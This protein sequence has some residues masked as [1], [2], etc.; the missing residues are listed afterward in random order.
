MKK[1]EIKAKRPWK[2][3]RPSGYISHGRFSSIEEPLMP[4]DNMEF[5]IV[6]QADFIREYYPTGHA[7]NDPAFYPDIYREEEE[8]VYDENGDDT[9][10]KI[11]RIYKELV[12]RYAFAFQ[13]IITIKQ[14]VHLCG[15]DIQ[16]ELGAARPTDEEQEKFL[17]FREGWL[18]KDMEVEF[19]KLA[20]SVKKTG[21]GA[22]VFYLSDRVLGC[23]SLS[24]MNGD[25][26]YPH[27]DSITGELTLF[28]RSYYDYDDEGNTTAEWLEVW[29]KKYMYR[30][31]K[32][33]GKGRTVYDVVI[34]IFGLDGYVQV[35]EKKP[36]GFQRVPVAY[37]R[38]EEGACWSHS[39][40]S[41]DGYE[42]SF[43]QMAHNNQAFGEPILILQSEG[44]SVDIQHDLNGTIKTLSMGTDDKA[45]YLSSQSA[46]ESYMKQID[47][48]YKMIY[49]QSFSVIPPELKSGDLPAAALKI[50]YSP[51]YEKAMI[52]A[53]EYQDVLRDMVELF[54]Y[55]YGV[56]T[57]NTI[58]FGNLNMRYYIEPYVHINN[59]AVVADLASAVQNGFM[60][61]QTAA[62]KLETIYTTN[63]EYD[64]ILKEN[65]E[66]REAALADEI[67]KKKATLLAS[68]KNNSSTSGKQNIK[69][70]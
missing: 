33:V 66:N 47:T 19:Y 13:Q 26:L 53:A 21:D 28:A 42:M 51:A 63:A 67:A 58:A 44:D 9:G 56:E 31:K 52:D 4:A 18:K 61:V 22:L 11:R 36:H 64:R 27:Y 65:K 32:G 29:D 60:S 39:Q 2:R 43:S 55:G 49:E 10:K 30:Y 57:E 37:K 20:S 34:G 16:F 68:A 50:L 14:L 41:I 45:S 25:T 38:D 24:Y 69:P 8:P 35:G 7:I 5:E 23:K 40:G 1:R 46:S 59:S 70:S 3:K 54:A 12:P 62:E 6:T 17:S 48:L 15:N